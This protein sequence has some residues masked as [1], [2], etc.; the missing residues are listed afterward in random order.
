MKE[1]VPIILFVYKRLDHTRAVVEA[2]KS[3][4]ES[5]D[6]IL[7][8][9]SDA[10]ASEKDIYEVNAVRDYISSIIG[11]KQI[12]V[13]MREHNFGIEKS[14]LEGVTY[15][16]NKYGKAIVLEDDILVCNQFLKYMNFCLNEYEDD[17]KIYTVTGYSFLKSKAENDNLYGLTG[18]FSAWGWGTWKNRWDN[19]K[20][21][22]S[23]KDVKY[24]AIH[25]MSLDNGQDFSYLFMHQYKNDTITW[26]V[27]W[28]YSCFYNGGLT[29]FPY[30]SMVN[31]IGMDGSGIHYNDSSSANNRI[32]PINVRAELIFPLKIETIGKTKEIVVREKKEADKKTIHKATKMLIRFWINVLEILLIGKKNVKIFY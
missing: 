9:F 14:E 1:Y 16:L 27:A 13:V 7:Y 22:F 12:Y 11:F 10:P 15:V 19:L 26:D 4:P 32:E 31:N 3:N 5:G 23:K 2:L 29:L 25:N 21:N 8:I 6:S 24:V 28:Y 30:N 18:S 17:K 20:R